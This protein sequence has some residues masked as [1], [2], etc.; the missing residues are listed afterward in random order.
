MG[1]EFELEGIEILSHIQLKVNQV[2]INHQPKLLLST[3]K[4]F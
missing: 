4:L 2:Y 3:Q 1:I